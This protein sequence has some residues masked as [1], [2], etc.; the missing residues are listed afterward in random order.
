MW[1]PEN[2]DGNASDN[3]FLFIGKVGR[4]DLPVGIMKA[5]AMET[6]KN[7]NIR[8]MSL[9]FFTTSAADNRYANLFGDDVVDPAKSPV[10]NKKNMRSFL[11]YK[12]KVEKDKLTI[13]GMRDDAVEDAVRSGQVRGRI[14]G[15]NTKTVTLPD[16]EAL[17]RYLIG[18]GDKKLFEEKHTQM[19]LRVK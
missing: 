10:W 2:K 17:L 18:G 1:K 6:D 19:Y 9:Y 7:H 15:N 11:L 4:Q 16:G 3:A 13:W 12:Y 8:D 5:M 14:E